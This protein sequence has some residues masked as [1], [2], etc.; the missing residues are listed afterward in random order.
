MSE[1]SNEVQFE[2]RKNEAGLF[3]AT[4]EADPT[5]LVIEESW[6]ELKEAIVE[7]LELRSEVEGRPVRAEP[8]PPREMRGSWDLSR[9]VFAIA[10][11]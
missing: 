10:R 4:S 1:R 3:I 6:S 8:Q 2:V 5:F 11:R 9:P 7:L